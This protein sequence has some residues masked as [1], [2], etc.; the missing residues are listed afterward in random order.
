MPRGCG[1]QASGEFEDPWPRGGVCQ[2]VVHT[3]AA[4]AAMMRGRGPL[5][6]VTPCDR[7]SPEPA[8]GSGNLGRH[9]ELDRR[10]GCHLG[11]VGLLGRL[12]RLL[13]EERLDLR[14]H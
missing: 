12:Q 10:L 7:A 3:R 9:L 13:L 6:A 2:Q 14:T 8:D 4:Q 1:N 11:D 5:D